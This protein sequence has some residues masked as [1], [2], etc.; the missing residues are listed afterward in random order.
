MYVACALLEVVSENDRDM[1]KEHPCKL[2]LSQL[3]EKGVLLG[4]YVFRLLLGPVRAGARRQAWRWL[5][6]YT[7]CLP[8]YESGILSSKP[9]EDFERN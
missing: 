7:N 9:K 1:D 6:F 4:M 2:K 8:H 5:G 3:V